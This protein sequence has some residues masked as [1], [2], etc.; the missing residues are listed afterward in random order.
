MIF[1]M[2]NCYHFNIDIPDP[3]VIFHEG[4]YYLITTTMHFFPGGEILRS[5]DLKKWEHYSYVFEKLES[6]PEQ[7]LEGD[8]Q[9]YGKGMWAPTLRYHDGI[10]Y[11]AFSSNDANK[12]YLFRSPDLKGPWTRNEIKG[13]YHDLSLLFDDGR[14]YVVYGN[15]RI[16]LTEL[17]KD[18]TG[19]EPGGLDRVIA[20]DSENPIL[21]FEGSHIYK[22]NGKYFLFLIHSL[23]DRWRRVEAMYVSDSLEGSFEGGDIFDNDL[24][25]RDSGIAQGG[26]VSGPFGDH[27]V[28]FQDSGAIGR[29]PV[30]VPFEWKDGRPVFDEDNTVEECELVGLCGDD[31]FSYGHKD[32]WQFNHEPDLSL[33]KFENG[34]H[35][36]T[37]KVC[38]NL[39]H[40]KNTLTQKTSG[41]IC[42]ARVTIDASGLNEGDFAGLSAFQ[43]DYA[44]AGITKE[45]GAY[46]AVMLS[47]E[48]KGGIWDLSEDEGTLEEKILLESDV[49]TVTVVCDFSND[50]ASCFVET[51]NGIKPIG[52]PHKLRFRLDHFTGA[53][54]ALSCFSTINAGG[55]AV[56][57]DFNIC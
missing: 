54:F 33:V 48:S 35:V 1:A 6:T 4:F 20:D 24:E 57:R 21:G 56:F 53:R 27:M 7:R 31:D 29:L 30:I 39:F 16:H 3:D 49:L 18:L 43:G 11:V 44:F 5:P 28:M 14:S 38:R 2:G 47:N 25:I 37:D 8:G 40:A 22:V 17:N 19:P 42:K 13:F 15:T 45:K 12:T 26:I 51:E 23:R 41:P 55:T 10:F 34:F 36:K 46:Y 9:I 32:Y 52:T 50:T